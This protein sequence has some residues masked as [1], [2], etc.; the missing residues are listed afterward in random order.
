MKSIT[1][2]QFLLPLISSGLSVG[3]PYAV[4]DRKL[5]M[6]PITYQERKWLLAK[7]ASSQA[8][9]DRTDYD[10]LLGRFGSLSIRS[11]FEFFK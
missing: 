8:I 9:G 2:E 5:N 7:F 10:T 3:L 1:A 6:M 11:C 4:V